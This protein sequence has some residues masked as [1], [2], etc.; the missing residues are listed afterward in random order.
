M[1]NKENNIEDIR[2]RIKEGFLENGMITG[3][4]YE[5]IQNTTVAMNKVWTDDRKTAK[6]W[7][8]LS[9]IRKEKLMSALDRGLTEYLF[10]VV[11]EWRGFCSY[12]QDTNAD[13]T[14]NKSVM[15]FLLYDQSYL[16]STEVRSKL[17][18]RQVKKAFWRFPL[19]PEKIEFFLMYFGKD[20]TESDNKNDEFVRATNLA[21]VG[22]EDSSFLHITS[23]LFTDALTDIL[24]LM[25][26]AAF[27]KQDEISPAQVTRLLFSGQDSIFQ[28]SN[29]EQLYYIIA[30]NFWDG[31]YFHCQLKNSGANIELNYVREEKCSQD[32][33]KELQL[34]NER[35]KGEIKSTADT[36]RFKLQ[37]KDEMIAHLQNQKIQTDKELFRAKR[38]IEELEKELHP[39]IEESN[40]DTKED[41]E[42]ETASEVLQ[43]DVKREITPE[44]KEFLENERFL[45]VV[46]EQNQT[47]S[48]LEKAF[49]NSAVCTN[50]TQQFMTTNYRAV[51]FMSSHLSHSLYAKYKVSCVEQRIPR[52]HCDNL[53]LEKVQW[54]IWDTLQGDKKNV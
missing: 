41:I 42:P 43:S 17:F 15:G 38:R 4:Q 34:E 46:G 9:D 11:P 19:T 2:I 35:L 3:G 50:S 10:N 14:I 6:L 12:N 18:N 31:F 32:E 29:K 21:G 30:K 52:I 26:M 54:T 44:M 28:Q 48:R 13:T 7:D 49:P 39:E 1:T 45:F 25:I 20:K 24:H 22:N 5:D 27:K 51:V 53:N 23:I 47:A 33:M 16:F 37:Q 8:S 40:T 36:S